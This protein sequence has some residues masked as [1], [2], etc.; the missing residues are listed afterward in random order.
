MGHPILVEDKSR[1]CAWCEGRGIRLRSTEK[2]PVGH[3]PL[4]STADGSSEYTFAEC[5]ACDGTGEWRDLP[6]P[7][8]FRA[9]PGALEGPLIPEEKILLEDCERTIRTGR[10]V[11]VQ[12]GSA[13]L[14]IRRHK[15]YRETH[16]SFGAYVRD[17]GGSRANGPTS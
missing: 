14:T 12:V 7:P 8:P 11:F 5:R 6:P 15:L 13:L 10:E 4:C 3:C 9:R 1:R 17:H 2:A 16:S